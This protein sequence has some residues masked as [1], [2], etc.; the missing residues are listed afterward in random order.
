MSVTKRIRTKNGK[1]VVFYHAE[2]YVRG[3]RLKDRTFDTQA[4][5]YAWHD[6][7]KEKL[8]NGSPTVGE[9]EMTFADCLKQYREWAETRLRRS[10]LQNY[11]C[12]LPYFTE[13]FL[14]KLRMKEVNSQNVDLWIKWLL[15]HPSAK[16]PGRKSFLKELKGLSV[17]LHWYRNYVDANYVIPITRRHR[18]MVQYKPVTAR[19]PDYFARPEEIRAWIGWLQNHRNP[20]YAE[21]ATFMVL[22]GCRVGEAT[23]LMWDAVDLNL[24]VARI[25]R[26]VSWDHWTRKPVLQETT[27]TEESTRLVVLPETLV[28]LLKEMKLRTGGTGLVFR[29]RDGDLLKY[30]AIQS[31]FNAGFAALNLPWRSTHICRHTYATMALF[32][33]RDLTSVQASLGHRSREVTE[34]YAKAVALLNSGTAEKTA[35]LFDLKSR[36]EN[37]VQNHVLEIPKR[38]N[39]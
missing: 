25:S 34:K 18:E 19:R 4:A 5:A 21:L 14:M 39:P 29:G 8:L 9:Q 13:S 17:V 12:R 2:V 32:A 16:N 26:T 7:E 10:S 35:A 23:G 27:K 38:Q 15:K 24:K 6:E 20:V 30:N 11:E 22:T 31:A 33:T 28:R 37:H 1:K 36:E 3:V